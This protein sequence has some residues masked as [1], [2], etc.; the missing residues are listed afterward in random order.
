MFNLRCTAKLLRRLKCVPG[1]SATSTT[2]LGDWYGNLFSVGRQ[3]YAMFTSERSLLTVVM[4]AREIEALAERLSRALRM[5]LKE[6]RV[7]S[8][9]IDEEI[10][11][12]EVCAITATANRSVLGSMNDLI[13]QAKFYLGGSKQLSLA[14]LQQR[15]ANT[16]MKLLDYRFASEAASELFVGQAKPTGTA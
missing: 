1:A 12:M 15:L 7:A 6:L 9:L 2:R 10:G 5:L 13:F 16:P 3:Q 11:Q 14:E 8:T 4:P